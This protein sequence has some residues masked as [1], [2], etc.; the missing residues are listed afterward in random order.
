MARNLA[1]DIGSTAAL[2]LANS[3]NQPASPASR[4][5]SH[6][7]Q[8]DGT[9][10]ESNSF[11]IPNCAISP[12]HNIVGS[13]QKGVRVRHHCRA[14]YSSPSAC[15]RPPER[16]A[17]LDHNG[18]VPTDPPVPTDSDREAAAGRVALWLDREDL[19]WLASHCACDDSTDQAERD[20]CARIRFRARAA[21]DK[22]PPVTP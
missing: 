16:S 8:H 20:R 6:D 15:G 10:S 5:G 12:A 9:T 3:P 1:A 7:R 17:G 11:W 22:A 19:A 13:N 4:M 21:L 2:L 18:A 14:R